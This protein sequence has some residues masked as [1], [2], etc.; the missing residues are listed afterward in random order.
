MFSI[1]RTFSFVFALIL[2]SG[3][4]NTTH[5]SKVETIFGPYGNNDWIGGSDSTSF[6]KL[7]DAIAQADYEFH[8]DQDERLDPVKGFHGKP[9]SLPRTM[10]DMVDGRRAFPG[11]VVVQL[12]K[13]AQ[14]DEVDARVMRVN[15]YFFAQGADRVLV[16]GFRGFGRQIYSDRIRNPDKPWRANRP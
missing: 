5:I 14:I 9:I 4:Q 6:S 13:L 15:Q 2:I 16:T 12:H 11:V 10:E 7:E 1:S 8:L 3:C